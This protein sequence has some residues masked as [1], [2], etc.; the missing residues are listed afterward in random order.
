M[1]AVEFEFVKILVKVY[2]YNYHWNDQSKNFMIRKLISI[3]VIYL[4]TVCLVLKKAIF[5]SK[6]RNSFG[7][8]MTTDWKVKVKGNVLSYKLASSQSFIV[9]F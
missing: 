8:V 7:W 9:V 1:V 4:I 5:K 6:Q 2:K 3:S